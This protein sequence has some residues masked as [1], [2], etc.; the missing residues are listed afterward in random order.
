[1]ATRLIIGILL[2]LIAG[3]GGALVYAFNALL[4]I[5]KDV[6]RVD[7]ETH[8][9]SEKMDYLRREL[10]KLDPDRYA[11]KTEWAAA[12]ER[13][14]G[15]SP[16]LD[17]PPLYDERPRSINEPPV[18]LPALLSAE[19]GARRSD[20]MPDLKPLQALLDASMH[21]SDEEPSVL[22]GSEEPESVHALDEPGGRRGRDNAGGV[23]AWISERRLAFLSWLEPALKWIRVVDGNREGEAEEAVAAWLIRAA[24]LLLVGAL[25]GL[26]RYLIP[27]MEPDYVTVLGCVSGIACLVLA[28]VMID[29]G[30]RIPGRLVAVTGLAVTAWAMQ[31]GAWSSGVVPVKW[32]IAILSTGALAT[33]L[34]GV[35][36]NSLLLTGAGM[37]AAFVVPEL[38]L[39]HGGSARFALGLCVLLTTLVHAIVSVRGWT[40]LR[41][42]AIAYGYVFIG[43]CVLSSR[44]PVPGLF[45]GISILLLFF[46]Q[47]SVVLLGP[48]PLPSAVRVGSYWAGVTSLF[49]Y[50]CLELGLMFQAFGQLQSLVI[51]FVLLLGAVAVL[52]RLGNANRR[53]MVTCFVLVLILAVM[54]VKLM[55]DLSPWQPG[56]NLRFN[57]TYTLQDAAVRCLDWAMV[58]AACWMSVRRL[59][60]FLPRL[61]MWLG[62][63]AFVGTFIF[64]TFEV[65]TCLFINQPAFQAAG[66]SLLWGLVGVSLTMAGMARNRPMVSQVGWL[67]LAVIV[68]KLLAVD[69]GPMDMLHRVVALGGVG[70][71]L[72]AGASPYFRSRKAYSESNPVHSMA[73][74]MQKESDSEHVS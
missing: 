33:T 71:L 27:S 66:L 46:A 11:P 59:F 4:R 12:P 68:F 41:I 55:V 1:M 21:E 72:L 61:A 28:V 39:M 24:V 60:V 35:R 14:T 44:Q 18:R 16:Q 30:A 42:L 73:D 53:D 5:K 54:A 29:H 15:E 17:A 69:M 26:F 6:R 37:L 9:L 63:L 65:N 52:E 58:A 19:V 62:G 13:Y 7:M 36:N 8:L 25:V 3:L 34:A 23:P 49:L 70:I 48:S 10:E 64:A 50:F 47:Q 40:L 31:H 51:S 57:A 2:L 38:L 74:P 43:F 67:F 56:V 20:I 45:P 22:P 32:A